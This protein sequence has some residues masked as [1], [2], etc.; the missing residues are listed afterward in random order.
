V[1]LSNQKISF[2]ASAVK[3]KEKHKTFAGCPGTARRGRC[4][5]SQRDTA[6]GTVFAVQDNH[7][8]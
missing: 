7:I 6:F 4:A 3:A 1:D 2:Y 5:L 8:F